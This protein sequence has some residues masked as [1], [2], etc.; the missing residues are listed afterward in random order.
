MP[1]ATET[2]NSHFSHSVAKIMQVFYLVE[3]VEEGTFGRG[4]GTHCS[5]VLQAPWKW[6]SRSNWGF[7]GPS[8]S[9]KSAPTSY[10]TCCCS[11]Y[12]IC[13]F[14]FLVFILQNIAYLEIFIGGMRSLTP[15]EGDVNIINRISSRGPVTSRGRSFQTVPIFS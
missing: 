8:T 11:K 2:Q 13:R 6:P 5:T 12:F 3:T 10:C 4:R 15:A 9:A 14:C 7:S 1:L